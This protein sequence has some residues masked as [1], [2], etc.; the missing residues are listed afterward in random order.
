M[1][2]RGDYDLVLM[3]IQMHEVDGLSAT[4]RIRALPQGATVPV[5]AMTAHAMAGD[6]EKSLAAGMNDHVVKP[7]DPDLLLRALLK[8]ID[9]A[10]LI[11]RSLPQRAVEVLDEPSIPG[12]APLRG[13]DWERGLANAGGQAAR[14]HKRVAAFRQEY[15]T[16]P[17]TMRDALS[18]GSYAPLETLAHN[19]KSGAFYL[20]AGALAALA[21]TLE[22]ALRAGQEERVAVLVP[23]LIVSLEDLL[24]GLARAAAP[25]SADAAADAS[26]TAT[27]DNAAGADARRLLTRL[28]GFLRADDA[29]ADD[30]M[31]DLET[32]LQAQPRHAAL[33][34]VL[35]Q[36]IDDIE[37]AAALA[38][39]ATLAQSLDMEYQ[40]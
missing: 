15:G 35:R 30:A 10:R 33:L 39:L 24:A 7:I 36:A 37:Y 1:V 16:A 17:R 2:A 20:G 34:P 3:D 22:D 27:A 6:R 13:V 29:R 26:A 18:G 21:G 25:G 19:L 11:G 14:L 8:W 28:E 40:P 9:P 5:I 32:A 38:L 4:R 31:A 23:D 12:L